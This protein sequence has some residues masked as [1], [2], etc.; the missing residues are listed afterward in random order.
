VSPQLLF[1]LGHFITDVKLSI[2]HVSTGIKM[3]GHFGSEMSR[4]PKSLVTICHF[5]RENV[6]HKTDHNRPVQTSYMVPP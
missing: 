1:E 2:G 4:D 5:A 6:Q 3:S